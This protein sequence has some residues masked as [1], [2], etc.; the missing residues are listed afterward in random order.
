MRFTIVREGSTNTP[1]ISASKWQRPR[2]YWTIVAIYLLIMAPFVFL[3]FSGFV[4]SGYFFVAAPLVAAF[5]I[6]TVIGAVKLLRVSKYAEFYSMI[7][8]GLLAYF[9][10][11]YF[12]LWLESLEL[13]Y[14]GI[15]DGVYLAIMIVNLAMF[16]LLFLKR[17][18]ILRART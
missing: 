10:F 18:Q 13:R 5:V 1:K 2:L 17:K 3:M 7:G 9:T 8:I 11:S 4:M 14:P 16:P 15:L 12:P 6:P